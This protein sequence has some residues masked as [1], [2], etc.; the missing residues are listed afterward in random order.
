MKISFTE[1]VQI[2]LQFLLQ[3]IIFF[4]WHRV[5]AKEGVVVF[6][7]LGIGDIWFFPVAV[8][9]FLVLNLS[10]AFFV[11]GR[12]YFLRFF[13]FFFNFILC[14]LEIVVLGYYVIAT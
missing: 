10:L 8:F 5:V 1:K 7:N 3:V 13:L 12:N 2:S 6:N 14:V 9:L 4:L 11:F